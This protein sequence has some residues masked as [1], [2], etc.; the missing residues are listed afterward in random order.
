MASRGKGS[1]GRFDA[2]RLAR[3]RGVVA[4]EVDAHQLPRV[5]DLLSEGPAM[6]AWRIE[7][8]AD[9]SGRPGLRVGLNGAVMLVCQRCLADFAWPLEQSTEVLLARDEGELAALDTDSSLEVVLAQGPTDPLT[10][11]EDELVLAL[12]FAPRHAEGACEAQ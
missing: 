7:G 3:E 5:A 12:P 8:I 10:L 2:M 6:V 9:A 4:G 1:P 11:V